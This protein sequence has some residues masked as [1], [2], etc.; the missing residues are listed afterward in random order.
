[1]A[2]SDSVSK[3]RLRKLQSGTWSQ[4]WDSEN[5]SLGVS[6]EVGTLRIRKSKLGFADPYYEL[7]RFLNRIQY[8]R[9]TYFWYISGMSYAYLKYI[10]GILQEHFRWILSISHYRHTL[11]RSQAFGKWKV[12]LEYISGTVL[13]LDISFVYLRYISGASLV[14]LRYFLG[15][16]Q[17]NFRHW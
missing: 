1:M 9:Y 11:S 17:V 10:I 14:H 7:T 2:V 4:N 6:L 8:L 13:R 16:S 12:D 3:L 5:V 15:I